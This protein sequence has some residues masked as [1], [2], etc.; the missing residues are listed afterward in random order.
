MINAYALIYL[1]AYAVPALVGVVAMVVYTH[2]LAPEQY[3]IFVIGASIAGVLSAVFLTWVRQAVLRYQAS[4]PE[5]DLR[6]EATIAFAA[7]VVVIACVTPLA[8]LIIRPNLSYGL[9]AASVLFSLTLSGFEVSQEFRRARL[10]PR[11]LTLIAVIRSLLSL[12]FGYCVIAFGGGGVALLVAVSMSFVL[13]NAWTFR[14]GGDKRLSEFSPHYLRQFVRYGV[15]FSLGATAITLH[16]TLDRL[17][18]AYLLGNSAAGYYGLASDMTRQLVAMLASSVAS[19]MFP[20]AFRSYAESGTAATRDRLCEGVELLFALL[21]PVTVWI[22]ASA[23]VVSATLLGRDFQASVA[24]ILP[25]LVIGRMFGAINQYYLQISFQLAEKP[26][27]QVAHETLILVL[28]LALLYPLTL[29]F[30]LPGTAAAVLAA[31]GIGIMIGVWLSRRAFPLPLNARALIRVVAST[32][33]MVAAVYAAKA[34]AGD[35]GVPALICVVVAGGLG[36]AGTAVLLDVAGVRSMVA[37]LLRP[38]LAP[39]E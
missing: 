14:G 5:L 18:V 37:A 4:S 11:R 26:F 29:A 30:G 36:Y 24:A 34:F 12:I 23:D 1:A 17:G 27:L 3:G 8:I 15:P 19:A 38:R 32:A 6:P 16:Y 10:D 35:R 20:I 25:L 2:L 28:N 7:S 9:I 21:L 13:S 39:A 31:E 22:A 33:V